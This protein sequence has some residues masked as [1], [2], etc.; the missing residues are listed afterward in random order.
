MTFEIT[1]PENGDFGKIENAPQYRK[2]A[3]KFNIMLIGTLPGIIWFIMVRA[4]L[5]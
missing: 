3:L 1:A 5:K 4:F 2:D